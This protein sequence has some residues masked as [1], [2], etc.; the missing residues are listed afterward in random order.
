MKSYK[1]F[2][3]IELVVVIVLVGIMAVGAGMLISR[4]IDAYNDQLR[5]QQLVDSAEM[6]LRKITGDI[7]RALPNSIRLVDNSPDSWAIEMMNT[8][9]GARYRDEAGGAFNNAVDM[10]DFSAADDEFNILGQFKN[11]APGSF[12]TLRVVIYSTSS[13]DV[14]NDAFNNNNPGIISP[15]GLTLGVSANEHHLALDSPFQFEFQSPTQRSFI[16]DGPVSYV[17]NRE[18]GFLTRFDGYPDQQTQISTVAGFPLSA[19]SGRV[20]SRVSGCNIDYLPGTAQRGGLLTLEIA[21]TN[22]AGESTRLL[23]QV[24]VDNVP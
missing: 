6:A 17:C 22:S 7:R 12:P 19:N 9:D 8:V 18:T 10:L 21:L 3:L 24:H 16:V 11:L 15:G 1:G 5:R 23:H 14:Y 4:P 13:A 2:S 20:A